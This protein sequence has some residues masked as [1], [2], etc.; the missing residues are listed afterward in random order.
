MKMFGKL[1]VTSQII[2]W[3]LVDSKMILNIMCIYLLNSS[4]GITLMRKFG[5]RHY[6]KHPIAPP[7]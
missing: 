6:I 1:L 7:S 5:T 3:K 2:R 4:K